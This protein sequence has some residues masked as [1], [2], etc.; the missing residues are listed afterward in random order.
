M[1]EQVQTTTPN[2][3]TGIPPP[4]VPL[5]IQGTFLDQVGV[6]KL[7]GNLGQMRLDNILY[8]GN[9]KVTTA[10]EIGT[11]KHEF[12]TWDGIPLAGYTKQL[13][14][15]VQVLVPWNMIP[16]Y[17]S[18]MAKVDYE[19]VY[20]PVKVS[21]CRVSIDV[22]ANFEN[23]RVEYDSKTLVNNNVHYLFDDP[24]EYLTFPVPMYWPTI[25]VNTNAYMIHQ[26]GKPNEVYKNAFLPKTRVSAFIA[27]PY[28][29]NSLQPTEV[30]VVVWLRLKPRQ[31]QGASAMKHKWTL[32]LSGFLPLPYFYE[33]PIAV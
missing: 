26:T 20:Q 23:S 4:E 14:Q 30:V 31:I 17:Y 12:S 3:P 16:T 18:R 7:D 28:I 11:L 21:D 1:M 22:V 25:N 33:K 32:A 27:T 15:G 8:L 10:D 19:L 6:Q 29:K 13:N 5:G 2:K 9:F 24:M